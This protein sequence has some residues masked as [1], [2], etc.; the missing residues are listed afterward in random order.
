MPN[1]GLCRSPVV[2]DSHVCRKPVSRK[3][4]F[5]SFANGGFQGLHFIGRS[6]ENEFVVD[7]HDH[8]ALEISIGEP[9]R[10]RYHRAFHDV[11]C[12]SL[13]GHVHRFAL[14]SFPNV[15]VGVAQ[16]FY[17]PLPSQS[18][19]YVTVR[20]RFFQK[21]VVIPANSRVSREERF[22]VSRRF[23]RGGS[24][25]FR[26]SETRNSVDDSEVY[27]FRDASHFLA[28]FIRRRKKEFR[29]FRVDVPSVRESRKKGFVTG[30]MREYA[31]FDLR[32]V[33]YEVFPIGIRGLEAFFYPVRISFSRRDVLQIRRFAR[34]SSRRRPE[35]IVRGTDSS[36]LPD[37][38]QETL[39]VRRSKFFVGA[40]FENEIRDR[41]VFSDFLKRIGVYGKTGFDFF[42]R[43]DAELFK[44]NVLYLFCGI[45]IKRL[46]YD[47][48]HF[49]FEKLRFRTQFLSNRDEFVFIDVH[50]VGFHFREHGKEFP[51][52]R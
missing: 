42:S 30:K 47:V 52:E 4:V 3:G 50:S 26:E 51:F 34:H 6:L 21:G 45:G 15:L 46:S 24:N 44:K 20:S 28:D 11:G 35:L 39:R 32:I 29:R 40:V 8:P 18:R 17:E 27:G 12:G 37:I 19:F 49:E 41:V 9:F 23:R 36:V 43:R 2:A 1:L 16:S 10:H 48:D 14:R 13:Y 7:L 38:F 5:H 31:K 22:D 33:R 25:G